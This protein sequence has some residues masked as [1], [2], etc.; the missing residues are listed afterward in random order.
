M[1][2]EASKDVE[3]KAETTKRELRERFSLINSKFLLLAETRFDLVHQLAHYQ[4]RERS[5]SLERLADEDKAGITSALRERREK[6]HIQRLSSLTAMCNIISSMFTQIKEVEVCANM[7]FLVWDA[8]GEPADMLLFQYMTIARSDNTQ[9]DRR[10]LHLDAEGDFIPY[11]IVENQLL[12]DLIRK[13][14]AKSER[15]DEFLYVD[16]VKSLLAKRRGEKKPK[17][18]D[19]KSPNFYRSALIVPVWHQLKATFSSKEL[20]TVLYDRPFKTIEL[21]NSRGTNMACY[22]FLTI[23]TLKPAAFDNDDIEILKECA[24]LGF[25]NLFEVFSIQFEDEGS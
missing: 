22:G 6:L 24:L 16:D 25:T 17:W 15:V 19:E 1:I 3:R 5:L 2:A 23:D 21:K 12:R 13:P 8:L 9:P 10:K 7:K 18:P 11:K 4:A 20:V 14:G